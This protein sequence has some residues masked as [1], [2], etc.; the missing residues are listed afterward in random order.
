M[1]KYLPLI[2]FLAVLFSLSISEAE[3][4]KPAS[5]VSYK[6]YVANLTGRTI[7]I[8]GTANAANIEPGLVD[9]R[10]T[11]APDSF[12]IGLPG[13]GSGTIDVTTEGNFSMDVTGNGNCVRLQGAL[14]T[15]RG[16]GPNMITYFV[17]A[18]HA[19]DCR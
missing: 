1:K 4:Q 17:Y 2:V 7:E 8:G 15:L 9:H 3:Q 11:N 10:F 14:E 16:L 12:H 19:G 18:W 5:S 13:V 6:V